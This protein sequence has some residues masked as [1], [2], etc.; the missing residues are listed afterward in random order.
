[1]IKTYAFCINFEDFSFSKLTDDFSNL[2]SSFWLPVQLLAS[3]S[4]LWLPASSFRLP[5]SG[6]RLPASGF[7]PGFRSCFR[8][9]VSVPKIGFLF[10]ALKSWWATK[11]NIGRF[12]GGG[13]GNQNLARTIALSPLGVKETLNYWLS[14]KKS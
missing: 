7:K 1:M 8:K 5:A 11:E 14:E 2:A 4:G 10:A 9:K 6:F 13:L 12:P 3:S